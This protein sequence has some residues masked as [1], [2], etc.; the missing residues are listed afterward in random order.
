MKSLGLKISLIVSLMIAAIIVLTVFIVTARTDELVNTL[1]YNQAKSANNNLVSS[2][3]RYTREAKERADMIAASADIIRAVEYRNEENLAAAVEAFRTGLDLI[4]VVDAEGDVLLRVHNDKRGD[5]LGSQKA[6]SAA[7]TTGNGIAIIEK[8]STVGVTTAGTAAVFDSTG[9]IIGAIKCGHDLSFTKYVDEIKEANNCEVTIF[10]GDTR[11]NTTILDES[12]ER[13]IGTQ[14]TPEVAETVIDRREDYSTTLPLFGKQYTVY[15]SPMISDGVVIG[16]LFA[17][18]NIDEILSHESE[19]ITWVITVSVLAG[20]AAILIL[21]IYSMFSV[22]GP[23]KKIGKFAEKIDQGELGISAQ[24]DSKIGVRSRD[25]VGQ[26]AKTL[27]E[28]YERLQGYIREIVNRM[29]AFSNGDFSH[30]GSFEFYGDFVL[31]GNSIAKINERMNR[32]LTEINRSTVQVAN[33]SK[34]LA[35]GSQALAQGATEQAA[36][37]EQLSASVSEIAQKT[38]M[39]AEMAAKAAAL[40]NTIKMNAEKG[41]RQMAE[42]T[43]A[44]KDINNASSSIGKVIKT[45]EDIAFQTNILALNASVEAA[46]AGQHGKGFAVVA[47]E[48]RNLASKSSE[49]AKDTGALIA[50][51]IEKAEFGSRIADETAA[52][53]YDIVAGINESSRIVGDIARSSEEQ[54]T[55]IEQINKGIDQVAHVIQQNSATAEQSAASSQEMSSQAEILEQLID[56]FK[57]KDARLGSHRAHG[58]ELPEAP[59]EFGKY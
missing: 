27:E 24:T 29:E 35:D 20:V 48:V 21:F 31:L 17:G 45:I 14:A 18:V 22:S 42:M 26:M 40:A 4:T 36:S 56:Q 39:N 1:T 32:T 52:S 55:G 43:A 57:L 30:D 46:R 50:N 9:K 49:A 41:N 11:M 58:G 13:V 53:L 54:S 38:K 19:M 33:G 6:I 34:Q 28:A 25:E 44:V 2:M 23:L 10:Y 51:S 12:G 7:L 59:A 5:N 15:Y 3:E 37:V 8:G 47:E 16:M